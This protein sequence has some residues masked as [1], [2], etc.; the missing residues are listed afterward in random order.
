[1]IDTVYGTYD[2]PSFVDIYPNEKEFINEITNSPLSIL[3]AEDLRVI[4]YLLYAHY[5]N[6]S[7]AASDTNQFKYRLFSII[8]M[9]GPTW[10]KRREIQAKLRNLTDEELTIGAKAIYNSASN[11]GTLPSTASLEELTAIDSQ[12]T[13]NY[14]K[15]KLEGYSLLLNLLETDITKEFITKF[16]HLFITIAQPQRDLLYFN[17]VELWN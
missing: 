11:P 17:E 4:Y 16:R 10:S 2:T 3:P 15:S 9:Y 7:I 8:Y 12:N 1:M 5:G 14:K 6:S 13:T